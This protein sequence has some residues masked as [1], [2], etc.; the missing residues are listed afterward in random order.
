[1]TTKIKTPTKKP[2]KKPKITTIS[3]FDL[4]KEGKDTSWTREHALDLAVDIFKHPSFVKEANAY[5]IV[6][7]ADTFTTFVLAGKEAAFPGIHTPVATQ[8]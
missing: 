8:D 3:P 6:T 5:S 2:N 7:L 1:M 4:Y